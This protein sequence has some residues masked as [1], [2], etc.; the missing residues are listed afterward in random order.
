MDQTAHP[1]DL[2]EEME[3]GGDQVQGAQETGSVQDLAK[4]GA[5]SSKSY[6]RVAGSPVLSSTLTNEYLK[7]KG[8]TWLALIARPVE[9]HLTGC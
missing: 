3:A 7:R 9:W 6:W 4:K 2:L 8:W 1:Y 5:G